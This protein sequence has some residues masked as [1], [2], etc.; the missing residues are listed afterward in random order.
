MAGDEMQAASLG[1]RRIQLAIFRLG[2]VAVAYLLWDLSTGGLGIGWRPWPQIIMA[3]PSETWASLA[4]Y[5][6]SG[7]LIKDLVQTL[8][9][10]LYGLLV[11]II[12]GL[13]FGICFAYVRFLGEAF[14]PIMGGLNSLP[15]L[16]IA[17]LFV[18]WFGLGLASKVALVWF[19]IFFII[20]YNTYLG[21]RNLDPDLVRVVRV[22][23]GRRAHVMRM[24]ILP[25]VLTWVFAALRTC[26]A[27]SLAVAVTGEFVGSTAGVGYRLL[28]ATG[29]L[30]TPM[31]FAL[32]FVLMVVG[33][34]LVEAARRVENYVLRWRPEPFGSV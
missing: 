19:T 26:I 31:V 7:L 28:F 5:A 14:D 18:V 34:V 4:E 27:F 21:V 16:A 11:A 1:S 2:I 20:Y 29:T 9:A 25:S 6:K 17:P 8:T 3:S 22:M 10:A 30:A 24:V 13:L 12:T 23:G 15:R 33:F 32:V